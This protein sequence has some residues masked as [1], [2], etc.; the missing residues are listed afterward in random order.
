MSI[1]PNL[2]TTRTQT[3]RVKIILKLK[4]PIK[5]TLGRL[6]REPVEYKPNKRAL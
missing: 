5:V 3:V 6:Y 1:W 4:P 2:N